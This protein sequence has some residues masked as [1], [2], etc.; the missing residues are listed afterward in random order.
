M[1]RDRQVKRIDCLTSCIK[2]D[3]N[4]SMNK[5]KEG[6]MK[7]DIKLISASLPHPHDVYWNINLPSLR[8]AISVYKKHEATKE[9]AEKLIEYLKPLLEKFESINQ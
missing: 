8:L 6:K 7:V 4:V 5:T 3:Y 9:K 2:I 1:L